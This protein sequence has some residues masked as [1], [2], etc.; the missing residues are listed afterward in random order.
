MSEFVIREYQEEDYEQVTILAN[1]LFHSIFSPFIG[2]PFE[3][4]AAFIKDFGLI[5]KAYNDGLYVVELDSSITGVMKLNAT[6]IKNEG[7]SISLKKVFKEYGFLKVIK[8]FMLF[9]A[10]N[11]KIACD[12]LYVDYLVVD[13]NFRSKGNGTA[14]LNFGK[15]LAIEMNKKRFSLNVLDS[16]PRG[17]QLYERFGFIFIKENKF[18]KYVRRRLEANADH[19]MEMSL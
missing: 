8:A 9:K 13:E 19:K 6:E 10:L 18:P 14:L 11:V 16:N 17:R 2:T 7:M 4:G 1:Q 15:N 5:N 12:E 3:K